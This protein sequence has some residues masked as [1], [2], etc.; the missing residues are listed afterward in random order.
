MK[1]VP[2]ALYVGDI[3]EMPSDPRVRRRYRKKALSS[4]VDCVVQPLG[5]S[6]MAVPVFLPTPP[7]RS[8]TRGWISLSAPRQPVLLGC[9]N[10]RG[11]RERGLENVPAGPVS[12]LPAGAALGL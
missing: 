5:G 7:G 6:F 9:A 3:P 1:I 4:Q 11:F 12:V 10:R 2:V 8:G